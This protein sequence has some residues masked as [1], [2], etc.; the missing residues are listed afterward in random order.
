M[1]EASTVKYSGI[2]KNTIPCSIPFSYGDKI[3]KQYSKETAIPDYLLKNYWWAYI[4]PK[5]VKFFERQWL[6]NLILWGN[7]AKLR[8]QVLEEL[9]FK[10]KTLQIAC[11]Y[12]DLTQCLLNQLSDKATLDIIDIAP[13]Q[14]KNLTNKLKNNCTSVKN[15]LINSLQNSA[16]L[17]F[18]NNNFDSVVIFFLLHELPTETKI[19]TINEAF[20]VLAPGGKLVFI[21]YHRPSLL[22]PFRYIMY[23]ILKWLEPFAMDMW[24]NEITD[25][26]LNIKSDSFKM[27]KET[28]FAGLYQKV[29]LLKKA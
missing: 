21:D 27:T 24:K 6:V 22:N 15:K 8:N 20:R 16:K 1:E 19:K 10:N 13:I 5:G 11:V 7:Y 29:V 23:P 9:K 12:G 4:H 18:A 2:E 14:L 25:W 3:S 17:N 28:F 26:L